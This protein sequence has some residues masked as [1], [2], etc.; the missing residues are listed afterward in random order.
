[1]NHTNKTNTNNIPNPSRQNPARC[2]ASPKC[3]TEQWTDQMTEENATAY[4]LN[5]ESP[6]LRRND[7]FGVLPLVR[8]VADLV[9]RAR[10]PLTISLS[11]NWG[12]GK[13]TVALA[14][15]DELRSRGVPSG[16]V[17]AWTT[18]TEELRRSLVV[19]VGSQMLGAERRADVADYVDAALTESR[20]IP[21]PPRIEFRLF[22]TV[23]A[24]FHQLI[25]ALALVLVLLF[26]LLLIGTNPRLAPWLVA[27]SALTGTAL[28]FLALRS[29]FFFTLS[30]ESITRG[31]AKET[32]E[33]SKRFG[34][35]VTGSIPTELNPPAIIPARIFIVVDNLD[36]LPGADALEALGAIRSLFEVEGSRCVFLVP[37]DRKALTAHLQRSLGAA[38]A[39]D[40]L[41]K[42]FGLDVQLVQPEPLDIRSFC[43]RLARQVFPDV[44]MRT[45]RLVSQII[46]SAAGTSPRLAQRITNGSSTRYRLLAA[47]TRQ[48]PQLAF[49]EGLIA[50]FSE[51]L[52]VCA[53]D[54]RILVE[55]RASLESAASE[56]AKYAAVVSLLGS[57]PT[58]DDPAPQTF[59]ERVHALIRYLQ[60]NQTVNIDRATVHAAVALRLDQFWRDV[61]RPETLTEALDTGQAAAF[62]Q[63]LGRRA[64]DDRTRAIQRSLE[65]VRRSLPFPRDA[66]NNL[67]AIAG[68]AEDNRQLRDEFRD[69]AVSIVLLGTPDIRALTPEAMLLATSEP[70]P[71]GRGRQLTDRI[72][73]AVTEAADR[74]EDPGSVITGLRAIVERVH[75]TVLPTVSSQLVRFPDEAL[76]P[77][78]DP[79]PVLVLLGDI[80]SAYGKRIAAWDAATPVDEHVGLAAGRL[81]KMTESGWNSNEVLDEV[82]TGL[83]RIVAGAEPEAAGQ[84]VTEDLVEALSHASPSAE[85]D[86][87]AAVLQDVANPERWPFLE[88]AFR[89]PLSEPA[90]GTR[91]SNVAAWLSSAGW[92][93]VEQVMDRSRTRLSEI[94]VD[95]RPVLASRWR[96]EKTEIGARVVAMDGD[97]G[98]AELLMQLGSAPEADYFTLVQQLAPYCR[99]A[100]LVELTEAATRGV[101]SYRPS[102]LAAHFMDTYAALRHQRADLGAMVEALEGR[103]A[104]ANPGDMRSFF[105]AAVDA[106]EIDPVAM[107]K[108]GGLLSERYRALGTATIDE[109]ISLVRMARGGATARQVLVDT[110]T[111]RRETVGEVIDRVP[112]VRKLLR[113]NW[114]VRAALVSRSVHESRDDAT[115]LL[116]EAI[117]WHR[118]PAKE[119][120]AYEDSLHE[121]AQL[122]PELTPAVNRLLDG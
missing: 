10:P 18:D 76:T 105:V 118:P 9:Q 45:T 100:R 103:I 12:V 14:V 95:Y 98:V 21:E 17:D 87:L 43:L 89:L 88:L 30:G 37:V 38:T 108:A 121:L 72:L 35:I 109:A 113:G 36:R 85:I 70:V 86:S 8:G 13:S 92:D 51:T 101:A 78:F 61:D 50:R 119:K 48:L 120:A 107:R 44:D 59:V 80:G 28:G 75:P 102:T 93:Q 32:Y 77:L 96:A 34:A 5:D 74:G 83:G 56:D 122:Y 91:R 47:G 25:L 20:L 114:S 106:H 22:D 90:Q 94:G 99:N 117:N 69:V 27:V 58:P 23:R 53:N 73:Q 84:P 65:Y 52:D 63:A 1:M 54:P 82:A 112:K 67:N 81:R 62:D 41:E 49:I 115:Q 110:I 60:T 29:G 111:S 39:R 42:F 64:R 66:V 4:W 3:A 57:E 97:A 79:D 2:R 71:G 33:L 11:G 26:V 7:D 24:N 40:Y 46:A 55:A 16:L 19:E 68:H 15:M 104:T 116:N 31:P 6:D